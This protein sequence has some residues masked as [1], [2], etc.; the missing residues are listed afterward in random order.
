[1]TVVR[2]SVAS[3]RTRPGDPAAPQRETTGGPDPA[4]PARRSGRPRSAEAEAAILAATVDLF[5]ESGFDAMSVEAVAARAGV[6]KTTIYRRWPTKEDLVVEAIGGLAPNLQ[7]VDTGDT[8][9]DL[10]TLVGNAVRFLTT[11]KAGAALPRIAGEVAASST[12]GRRYV[13]VV[14][15]P[16]RAVLATIIERGKERGELR[17]DLDVELAIDSIMGPVMVRKLLGTLESQPD[18]FPDRLTD[19]VLRGLLAGS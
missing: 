7:V 18:D 17:G 8:R 12:L 10:R 5:A 4:G 14:L 19:A 9:D 6:G 1:M 13:E 2:D 11:T 16:R 15:A 3:R